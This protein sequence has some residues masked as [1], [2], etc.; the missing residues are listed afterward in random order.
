MSNT[1][2]SFPF[3]TPFMITNRN[4]QTTT[5]P[6]QYGSNLPHAP[7][8]RMMMPYPPLNTPPI[9]KLS[10]AIMDTT[11][12]TSLFSQYH[13]FFV[14]LSDF[15]VE[16]FSEEIRSLRNNQASSDEKVSTSKHRDVASLRMNFA[17][18]KQFITSNQ[19]SCKINMDTS[20][21]TSESSTNNTYKYE[22]P[23]FKQQ[24]YYQTG[25]IDSLK[26]RQFV[27]QCFDFNNLPIGNTIN[28]NLLSICTGNVHQE[29]FILNNN[30]YII[31]KI[32]FKCQ[33]KQFSD[34][35]VN[36]KNLNIILPSTFNKEE[37]QDCYLSYGFTSG[38]NNTNGSFKSSPNPNQSFQLIVPWTL[39][40]HFIHGM[41]PPNPQ[42]L[43]PMMDTQ[44]SLVWYELS[45]IY[46]TQTSLKELLEKNLVIRLMKKKRDVS[47][48]EFSIPLSSIIKSGILKNSQY[49]F[50]QSEGTPST[51]I[52]GVVEFNNLPLFIQ[53]ESQHIKEDITP[54]KSVITDNRFNQSSS[55]L[56]YGVNVPQL[57]QTTTTTTSTTTT[58]TSTT[59]TWDEQQQQ[60]LLLPPRKVFSPAHIASTNSTTMTT[61]IPTPSSSSDDF[62]TLDQTS[63]YST[64]P[65]QIV[66]ECT[67]KDMLDSDGLGMTHTLT[68]EQAVLATS[69]VTVQQSP[70]KYFEVQIL[71]EGESGKCS[72]G[73]IS[74]SNSSEK[75]MFGSATNTANTASI[76]HAMN[77]GYSSM[78]GYL[79]GKSQNN[80]FR[81]RPFGP[82]YRCGDVIGCGL[83]SIPRI[84]D[85]PYGFSSSVPSQRYQQVAY[86]TRNGKLV[87]FAPYQVEEKD[88]AFAIV[89]RSKYMKVYVNFGQEK[90]PFQFDIHQADVLYFNQ[91]LQQYANVSSGSEKSINIGVDY[92]NRVFI[93][94]TF[95][96]KN[97]FTTNPMH[98]ILMED[99]VMQKVHNK[100]KTKQLPTS[101]LQEINQKL[102]NTITNPVTIKYKTPRK[103]S[104]KEEKVKWNGIESNRV[105]LSLLNIPKSSFSPNEFANVVNYGQFVIDYHLT[106]EGYNE[107]I[108][109]NVTPTLV[110]I[111]ALEAL[112]LSKGM[113]FL[114]VGSGC[115]YVTALVS[116]IVGEDGFCTG[117]DI[118]E[119]VIGFA[120]QKLFEFSTSSHGCQYASQMCEI[121]FIKKNILLPKSLNIPILSCENY[122]AIFCGLEIT[123]D[124]LKY[125]E[126]VIKMNGK[127]VAA[128]PDKCLYLFEFIGDDN[129][130]RTKLMKNCDLPIV[131]LPSTDDIDFEK[132]ERIRE[133]VNNNFYFSKKDIDLALDTLGMDN[134]VN[135]CQFLMLYSDPALRATETSLDQIV[136][137]L[138]L[139]ETPCNTNLPVQQHILLFPVQAHFY[140]VHARNLS[141]FF[142]LPLNFV[143]DCLVKYQC[144]MMQLN[145]ILEQ[146]SKQKLSSS[147]W[148]EDEEEKVCLE[149][150]SKFAK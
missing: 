73:L 149:L 144:N 129:W 134:L 147:F 8:M 110:A 138:K 52:S 27:I 2:S 139:F 47:V 7:P 22:W 111:R 90:Q 136:H 93:Q 142:Q 56:P 143:E 116:F 24:F 14:V 20:T 68:I 70:F 86:F 150:L 100:S 35:E 9:P 130:K 29:S 34:V 91:K 4:H 71:D 66:L 102:I 88:L 17:N 105:L 126:N 145:P 98:T 106:P 65:S 25:M 1:A 30:Q 48:A 58:T 123:T 81:R 41:A 11:N 141:N 50:R 137:A 140:L 74:K 36:L 6:P 61:T 108:Q 54:E 117:V 120:K 40:W 109:F 80:R 3:P 89:L 57:F 51:V 133:Y 18:Y 12:N 131:V 67:F 82:Q 53:Q 5:L 33:M 78:D 122:D 37:T 128:L 13:S 103:N 97:V 92:F 85:E 39:P 113:K 60:Q 63:S 107:S 10:S 46:L 84:V 55:S 16:L 45:S 43:K 21:N 76:E 69:S 75:E 127:L 99:Y 146:I 59:S 95:N 77:V 132:R 19:S 83:I 15:S 62:L 135:I 118:D 104:E 42:L 119:N 125:F 72:I 148:D 49:P 23:S 112:Q 31:G 115:G 121:E 124:T 28:F 38:E 44:L 26:K 64:G 79:F 87:G 96:N 94:N 101:K 32:Q 114:E